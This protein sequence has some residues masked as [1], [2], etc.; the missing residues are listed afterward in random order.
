M[1]SYQLMRPG[2][3]SVVPGP[4]LKWP[5]IRKKVGGPPRP[6]GVI[7]RSYCC[8]KRQTSTCCGGPVTFSQA[9]PAGQVEPSTEQSSRH[10]RVPVAAVGPQAMVE[11]MATSAG[12]EHSVTN[13]HSSV[14]K[15]VPVL[16]GGQVG[17]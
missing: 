8:G 14:Q 2:D 4:G 12:W 5:E 6:P 1:L 9:I 3:G 15:P 10:Q 11:V 7:T 16:A 17:R 13:R